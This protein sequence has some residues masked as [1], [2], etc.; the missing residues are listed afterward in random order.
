M[1]CVNIQIRCEGTNDQQT[2]H[3]NHIDMIDQYR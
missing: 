1:G 2:T 3:L